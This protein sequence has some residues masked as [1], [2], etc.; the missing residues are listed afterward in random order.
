MAGLGFRDALIPK[1]VRSLSAT[2]YAAPH[3]GRARELNSA[4]GRGCAR[5]RAI[6]SE[7]GAEDGEVAGGWWSDSTRPRYGREAAE[8]PRYSDRPSTPTQSSH[9]PVPT[10]ASTRPIATVL[11]TERPPGTLTTPGPTE[12]RTRPGFERLPRPAPGRS[13]ATPPGSPTPTLPILLV[14]TG[15]D[16]HA[17]SKK[18]ARIPL[19]ELLESRP[20]RRL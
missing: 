9:P 15:P 14:Q 7:H 2:L 13:A 18:G 1:P 10:P 8:L 20:D 6:A 12:D 17:A 4:D 5:K 3:R 16:P 11:D 19:F